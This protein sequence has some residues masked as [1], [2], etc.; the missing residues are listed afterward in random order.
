MRSFRPILIITV[1]ALAGCSSTPRYQGLD[2][3]ALFA[4]GEEAFQEGDWQEAI[5]A[6]ERLVATAPGFDRTAEARMYTARAYFERKEYLSA[7]AEWDRFLERFP[8][9]GMAP[10][11]SLG[12]CRAYSELA[13]IAPRDQEYTRR[14]RDA[15]RQTALDFQGMNVAAEADSVRRLMVD[16]LAERT[17][18]EGR[19]YQRR[20]LHNSAVLIF[21]DLVDFYPETTWAP[22]GFLALYRSYEA[23]GWDEEMDEVRRRLIFLYPESDAARELDGRANGGDSALRDRSGSGPAG[24]APGGLGSMRDDG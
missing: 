7:A 9:H 23:M 21:Q 13:P 20:G 18:L 10:E 17:Y 3:T 6:F 16:R 2:A 12:I 4:L 5:D 15:C 19:F 24:S 14:A 1:L 8:S 22:E 11:A